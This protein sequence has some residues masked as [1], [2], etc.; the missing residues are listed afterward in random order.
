M[1]KLVFHVILSIAVLADHALPN[2]SAD[3]F[4]M[5]QCGAYFAGM[6]SIIPLRHRLAL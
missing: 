4:D 2:L 3:G 5:V 1:V 6:T